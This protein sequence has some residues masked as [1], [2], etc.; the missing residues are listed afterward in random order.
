[1]YITV[2]R[3][4]YRRIVLVCADFVDVVFVITV[5]CWLCGDVKVK[6]IDYLCD[7]AVS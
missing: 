1:M 4:C 6:V 7:S 2:C 5:I 3:Y